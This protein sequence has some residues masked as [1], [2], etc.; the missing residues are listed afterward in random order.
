MT[1]REW[2]VLND[3]FQAIGDEVDTDAVGSRLGRAMSEAAML[4][5]EQKDAWVNPSC[6][7][8]V[9]DGEWNTSGRRERPDT[10]PERNHMEEGNKPKGFGQFDGL[11]RKLVKVPP[12][13]LPSVRINRRGCKGPLPDEAARAIAEAARKL[14]ASERRKRK[15]K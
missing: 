14:V 12:E 9:P 5:I 8:G 6:E 3:L 7:H 1:E 15:R 10:Q 11:M 2:T 4:L 13:S